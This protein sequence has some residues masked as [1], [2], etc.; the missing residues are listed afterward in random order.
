[1]S[2]FSI[3]DLAYFGGPKT[4]E[5]NK[6]SFNWPVIDSDVESTVINQLHT[7]ISI[8]DKSSVFEEFETEFSDYHGCKHGLLYNS[9]TS[10]ILAMFDSI[11]IGA[12]DYVLC[13][14]YT[15]H[16]T[17][18]PL[19]YLG[20]TPIFCDCNSF[21]NISI[22]SIKKNYRPGVKAVIITHMWGVP[23]QD[24]EDICNFCKE[25]GIYLFEDCSHAHGATYKGKPVGS[26]GDAAAWS[27]Q[28]QKIITGG[29]GGILLTDNDDLYYRALLQGHYNKRPKMEI[30]KDN[31][32]H[33]YFLTGKG[34]KLRAH[35]IAISIA[36]QQFRK[37]EYFMKNKREHASLII[38][39]ISKY[40]FL[41]VI[42]T[43]GSVNS[44][45]ALG[46]KFKSKYNG[47]ISK[48][49]FVKLLVSEGL[50]EV[51]IPGSTGL[52]NN[53]PIFKEPKCLFNNSSLGEFLV[54]NKDDFQN[55][56]KFYSEFI[57]IPVWG[58]E[59]D[60]EVV[61]LYA[62]GIDKVCSVVDKYENLNSII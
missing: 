20:A 43:P 13:P 37:I 45:Y 34:L 57:K 46:I 42:N 44:W 19:L 59:S 62:K 27:L 33:K 21:G 50:I 18:T 26:F 23:V 48:Q 12:G 56:S 8:Y 30:P 2:N 39:V 60:Y 31:E 29:E 40:D 53:L 58:Y 24:L 35:P 51:D 6:G 32:L 47:F 1:M 11:C 61:N 4:I 17:V 9:G 38:D 41:D 7:T 25:K 3:Q 5:G 15:F 10:S 55:A 49:N 22:E 28:G 36:L 52:L 16:A 54:E 14:V